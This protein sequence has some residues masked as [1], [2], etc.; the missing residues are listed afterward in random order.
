MK[1]VGAG[2]KISAAWQSTPYQKD[3][4]PEAVLPAPVP[5]DAVSF[6]P[7]ESSPF[8][9]SLSLEAPLSGKTAVSLVPGSSFPPSFPVPPPVYL[10]PDAPS[11]LPVFLLP[12]FSSAASPAPA[13]TFPAVKS[14][15]IPLPVCP[16]S[17]VSL[18]SV[19]EGFRSSSLSCP[20]GTLKASF[21]ASS[22]AYSMVNTLLPF[23]SYK[24]ASSRS[25]LSITAVRRSAAS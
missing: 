13:V 20:A 22:G 14:S 21:F 19:S 6:S 15:G 4:Q 10:P 2:R 16:S 18:S 5:P 1:G 3:F 25:S 17:S 23:P 8:S 12:V 7:P 9:S 24:A 11:L